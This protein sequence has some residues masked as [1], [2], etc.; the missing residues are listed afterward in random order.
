[1]LLDV[2][3]YLNMV[4]IDAAISDII[5]VILSSR[6]SRYSDIFAL[7]ATMK[8]KK[9]AESKKTY[10]MLSEIKVL[11]LNHTKQGNGRAGVTHASICHQRWGK[12]EGYE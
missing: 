2:A 10:S 12:G 7:L 8:K 9:S 3:R 11:A 1:M 6:N 4:A 5:M